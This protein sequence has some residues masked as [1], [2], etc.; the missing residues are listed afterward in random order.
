MKQEALRGNQVNVNKLQ[1]TTGY[2][3][4]VYEKVN[5]IG[6]QETNPY[7]IR[8]MGRELE[9]MTGHKPHEVMEQLAGHFETLGKF[10]QQ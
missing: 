7:K 8:Q 5:T 2:W 6:R 1:E 4:K 10:Y 3:Q 9:T